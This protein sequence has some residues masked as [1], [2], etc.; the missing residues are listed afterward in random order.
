MYLSHN[1]Q[2]L[3][4]PIIVLFTLI[5]HDCLY[6]SVYHLQ[7]FLLSAGFKFFIHC[8]N[9]FYVWILN[10]FSGDTSVDT[11]HVL[12][13]SLLWLNAAAAHP[14]ALWFNV[15]C[16]FASV[17]ST[18]TWTMET[19]RSSTLCQ[20]KELGPSSP[21]IKLQEIYMHWWGLTGQY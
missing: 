19:M 16:I 18:Q 5:L 17:S 11:A 21:L 7:I 3:L 4:K 10:L 2:H 6:V 12:F 13:C 20:E 9:I 1:K 14:G 8:A 15:L